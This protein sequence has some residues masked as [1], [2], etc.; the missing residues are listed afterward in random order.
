MCQSVRVRGVVSRVC[1]ASVQ[2]IIGRYAIAL[3]VVSERSAGVV[4]SCVCSDNSRRIRS[5]QTGPGDCLR[6]NTSNEASALH[7]R[8]T[9]ALG[10]RK[11][12]KS[13]VSDSTLRII[14]NGAVEKVNCLWALG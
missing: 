6:F 13:T 9:G 2:V 3:R 11:R 10:W 1:A 5:A 4:L 8:L 12:V 7:G 14:D